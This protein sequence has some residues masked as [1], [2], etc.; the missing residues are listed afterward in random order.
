MSQHRNETADESRGARRHLVAWPLA[1]IGLT[2]ALL[3][4][5]NSVSAWGR[6][7]IES[8]RVEHLG[9]ADSMS[10]LVAERLADALE[11]L[12]PEQRSQLE[13]RFSRHTRRHRRGGWH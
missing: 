1:L 5:T 13:E 11:I 2:A 7:A 9:K 3:L 12:T 6:G 10:R 4:V 8:L